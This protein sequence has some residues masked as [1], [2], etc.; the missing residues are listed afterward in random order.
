MRVIAGTARGRKIQA[1]PGS[2]TRPI[3]DRAKESIFNMLVSRGAVV[4]A[5]VVDLFAGSGSFGIECLSRGAERVVFV[6]SARPAA[7]TIRSNL[8]HLGFTDRA[9]IEVGPVESLIGRLPSA[10]LA[11]CDPPYALDPWSELLA[12]L[13]ADLVV[14]H[15]QSDIELPPRWSEIRRR[16]YGRAH[17]VIAERVP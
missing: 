10:D 1:P 6:E 9:S 15:A 8:E 3:T 12:D 11:F 2:G 13:D 16:T 14:G 5:V 4:D 7:A 17:I